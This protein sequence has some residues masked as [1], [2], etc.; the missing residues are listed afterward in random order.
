[1]DQIPFV[2]VGTEELAARSPLTAGDT[3]AC[4]RCGATHRAETHT[5]L[6]PLSV[7]E[8]GLGGEVFGGRDASNLSPRPPPRSG[9]GELAGPRSRK[10]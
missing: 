10:A 6:L 9:E 4:D 1:M 5:L 8:R 7:S 2:A 3:W